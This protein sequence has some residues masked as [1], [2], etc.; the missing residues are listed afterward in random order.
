[1][2]KHFATYMILG[3]TLFSANLAYAVTRAGETGPGHLAKELRKELLTLP[4]YSL[5]DRFAFRVEGSTITLMGQV[6]RPTLKSEAENVAKSLAGVETVHNQI[7]VL[8][9]S[10]NDDRLRLSLYRAIYGHSALDT[11]AIRALPPIHILVRNGNVTLEGVVANA[12]QKQI[13]GMQANSV[14]GVFS[15]TNNLQVEQQKEM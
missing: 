13:A 8:P 6:T 14:S 3:F 7:E 4:Y 11:L 15:V 12:M 5:F 2:I 9:L 10:P 1:M